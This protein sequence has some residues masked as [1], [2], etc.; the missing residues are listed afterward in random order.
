MLAVSLLIFTTMQL[1]SSWDAAKDLAAE[2]IYFD[3]QNTFYCGCE[4]SFE[5][6]SNRGSGDVYPQIC[7]SASRLG[8]AGALPESIG[9]VGYNQTLDWEHVV[10]ASL[11]PAAQ[12]SC[13]V[14]H[15]RDYCERNSSAAQEILFDLHNLVPASAPLN[16]RRRDNRYLDLPESTSDYGICEVEYRS[17]AFEPPDCQKGDVARIWF[18]MRDT[19]GVVISDDEATMFTSW[20]TLDPVSPWE[21]EREARISATTGRSN[22]YVA[23]ASPD[24]S[25]HC[26]WEQ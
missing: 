21:L 6:S 20:S 3:Q 4:M 22:P 18:Y 8:G 9:W 7:R 11:T 12:M 19:H 2:C 17:G 14:D 15:G 13:W 24:E 1:P 5:P 23:G 16:R 25:G 26:A 10:P